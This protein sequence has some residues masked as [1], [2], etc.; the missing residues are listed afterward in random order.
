MKNN[1]TFGQKLLLIKYDNLT[2]IKKYLFVLL[3]SFDYLKERLE[4][5]NKYGSL[6]TSTE[7]I[8]KVINFINLSMFLQTGLKPNLIDR[9]LNL[10]QTYV[11]ENIPRQFGNKYLT[12]E[13]VWNGFIVSIAN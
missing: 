13:L 9:I 12:R 3:S 11:K 7:L 1:A 6:I 4:M 10:D 2:N 8:I 5:S